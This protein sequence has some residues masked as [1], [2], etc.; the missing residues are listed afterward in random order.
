VT[1]AG[2]PARVEVRVE[3]RP[4]W[5]FRLPRRLGL[6]RLARM[7]GNVLHRL[8]HRDDEPVEIRAVQLAP[9]RVL[10]G[11]RAR[12]EEL[13]GWGIWRTRRS[14]GID[15]DLAA[16]HDRFR[17]DPVIGASVRAHPQLRPSSRPD[18]FEALWFAVCEQLIE[19][20]RAA[21]IQRRMIARL[22][23][24][25]AVTGLRDGPSAA[26]VAAQAPALLASFDLAQGRAL[27]LRR[28]AQEVASGRVDLDATDPTEQEQG[29]RRLRAIPG[30]GSWTVQQLALRGQGRLDQ[31]PAGDLSY[32]KLV[33][34]LCSDAPPGA[35]APRATEEEVVRFFEP[36]GEWAGLAGAHA[37]VACGMGR[38]GAAA[39]QLAA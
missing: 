29:W 25:D 31:L 8:I 36:Y 27:A 14:L 34:R 23:R 39:Q 18:P 38:S 15:V 24:R 22:G 35:P 20:E 12:T 5:P 9:D 11:A 6:D 16:F 3:V 10:F 32:V 30:I 33:G 4:P 28:A 17:F 19:Y 2:D 7:R 1:L 21:V 13:A 37:L 26:V